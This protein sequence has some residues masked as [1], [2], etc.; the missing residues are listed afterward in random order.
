MAVKPNVR[1]L[2]SHISHM[3]FLYVWRD[4]G[5]TQKQGFELTVDVT[6]KNVP[7]QEYR[8]FPDRAP[9]LLDGTYDFLS[10]LHHEPYYYRARGDKRF[11]NIAQ[12][13]NDWD[14]S[15][16]TQ[17]I[18]SPKDLEGKTVIAT[19]NAP[20]VEWA[21]LGHEDVHFHHRVQVDHVE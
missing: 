13:Q 19:S 10:G 15:V 6:G 16:A 9:M 5:V 4:S 11:I 2:A 18:K 8:G 12:A 7:G 14:D 21:R 20:C 3:A 17:E 1:M